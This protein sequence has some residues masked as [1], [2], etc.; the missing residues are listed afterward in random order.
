ML[1]FKIGAYGTI[2]DYDSFKLESFILPRR[3]IETRLRRRKQE[4]P[5]HYSYVGA[6]SHKFCVDKGDRWVIKFRSDL[7]LFDIIKL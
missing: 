7:N 4:S 1:G 6:N 3:Q 5:N 2:R